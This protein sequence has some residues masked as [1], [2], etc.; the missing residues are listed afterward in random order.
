MADAQ[1]LVG[2]CLSLFAGREGRE[3]KQRMRVVPNGKYEKGSWKQ[4][5]ILPLRYHLLNITWRVLTLGTV[6]NLIVN[7]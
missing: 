2:R 5:L 6:R 7:I 1:Q 3:E 4:P